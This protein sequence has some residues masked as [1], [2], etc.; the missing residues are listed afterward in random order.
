VT[1]DGAES[2]APSTW[3]YGL[4]AEWWAAFN[5]DGPEIGYFGSFVE[6][7]QP[8]LDAG[9]GTGR[10]LVPWLLAGYD[11]D[12]SDVSPDMIRLCRQRARAEGFEPTLRVQPLHVLDMPRRY[13]TVVACGV[14]GLG[15]TRSQDQQALQRFHEL[16]EPGG[17][18]LL[19][20]QVPYSDTRWAQWPASERVGHFP[21]PWPQ[22]TTERQAADGHRYL[23][24][25]RA[26]SLDP[27][28]QSIVLEMRMEK[29][30][31]GVLLAS[32]DRTISVRSFFRDEMLLML[33]RAGFRQVTVTGD[34]SD[35]PPTGDHRFLVYRAEA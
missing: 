18:L 20:H 29:R 24:C 1:T 27:L 7:G 21:E 17:T 26:L 15:G 13:R 4:V 5:T 30:R 22:E 32:E 23:M 33:E 31:D 8:A 10:L 34:Y 16:L 28:D 9:C 2:S 6:A 19:D 35:D 3:H 11:V 12:G 14:L 25:A